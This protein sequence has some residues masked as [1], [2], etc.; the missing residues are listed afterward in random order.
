MIPGVQ[1]STSVNY[2]AAKLK[3]TNKGAGWHLLSVHEWAA[4]CLWA[5]AN[6]TLPRGNTYYGQSHEARWETAPRADSKMPGEASGTG[7][8]NTGMGPA[9]W[10]HDHTPFGI[11]DLVGNVWEWLDQLKLDDGQVLTT[12]DN[13]PSIAESLWVRHAA[14]FDAVS[15]ITLSDAVT[16]RDGT[17]GDNANAGAPRNKMI[18]DIAKSSGYTPNLLLRQLLI[19]FSAKPLSIGRCYMRN[20]GERLPLRGGDWSGSSNAGVGALGLDIS[21]SYAYADVGFRP[22]FFE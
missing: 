6:E 12:P 20:Y 5:L 3:C 17:S 19:E 9:T 15:E 1:P 21:R 16:H 18:A 7:R 4:A 14:Y 8:T 11:C 10:S 13:D 22:A 2:D